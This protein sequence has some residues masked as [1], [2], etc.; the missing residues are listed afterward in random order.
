MMCASTMVAIAAHSDS[1]RDMASLF[2]CDRHE[3]SVRAVWKRRESEVAIE[4]RRNFILRVD[5]DGEYCER[6]SGPEHATRRAREQ[7]PPTLATNAPIARQP[8]GLRSRN[9]AVSRQPLLRV[10]EPSP[11]ETP[12]FA[13]LLWK[14]SER[15][16][17]GPVTQIQCLSLGVQFSCIFPNFLRL[18]QLQAGGSSRR[19]RSGIRRKLTAH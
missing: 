16:H 14:P 13:R 15:T 11:F 1:A 19:F 2:V 6:P 7:R 10:L 12:R 9:G 4:G 17:Q 3:Q 18:V 8:P 5:D